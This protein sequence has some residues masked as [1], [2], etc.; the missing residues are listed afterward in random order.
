MGQFN[1]RLEPVLKFRA[2]KEEQEI[3]ALAEALRYLEEKENVYRCCAEEYQASL[4]G[5]GQSLAELRQW[6]I[7]RELLRARLKA[8]AARLKEAVARVDECRAAVLSARQERLTVD[9]VKDRRYALF[10]AEENTREQREND[11]L[12]H[13]AYHN[14]EKMSL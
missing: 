6:V 5:N 13:L 4:K 14:R 1:F 10:L 12:S 3:Q 9:K 7:Y 8:E 2:V 11:E